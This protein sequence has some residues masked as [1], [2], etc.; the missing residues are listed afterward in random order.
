MDL[1]LRDRGV[2]LEIPLSRKAGEGWGEGKSRRR[3]S[4][5]PHPALRATFSRVAGEGIRVRPIALAPSPRPD[6]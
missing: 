1:R 2:R 3:P 4:K 6:N 5:S